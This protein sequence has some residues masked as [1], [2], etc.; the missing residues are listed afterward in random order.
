M[1]PLKSKNSQFKI[2]FSLS[3]RL[4]LAQNTLF[5]ANRCIMYI[6]NSALSGLYR[7]A[8]PTQRARGREV[9]AAR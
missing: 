7:R 6:L 1:Y 4:L 3:R 2:N 5:K 9:C 8:D